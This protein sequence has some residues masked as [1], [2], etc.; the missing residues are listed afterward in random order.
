MTTKIE[1]MIARVREHA[2]TRMEVG[3]PAW[4]YLV[5]CMMDTDIEDV[6]DDASS[7]PWAIFKVDRWLNRRD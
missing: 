5:D 6:I 1:T 4:A 2:A 3:D 7:S